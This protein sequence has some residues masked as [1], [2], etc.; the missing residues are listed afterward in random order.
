MGGQEAPNVVTG[1]WGVLFICYNWRKEA[2][3]PHLLTYFVI[4]VALSPQ[5]LPS[6]EL[7]VHISGQ[8]P[9]HVKTFL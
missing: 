2:T 3:D 1:S 5:I 4:L 7:A 6:S 9:S 8:G